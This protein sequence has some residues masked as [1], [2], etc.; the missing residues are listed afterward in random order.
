MT[1]VF[2]ANMEPTPGDE[3]DSNPTPPFCPSTV[4]GNKSYARIPDGTG[5]WID[6]IPTRAEQMLRQKI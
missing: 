2:I 6:P 3:N 4:P 5:A 1:V